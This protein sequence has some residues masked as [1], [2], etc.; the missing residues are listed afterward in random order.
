[1]YFPIF[2]F[3]LGKDKYIP[4]QKENCLRF[5]SYVLLTHFKKSMQKIEFP[6]ELEEKIWLTTK[7][8]P[9]WE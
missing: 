5:L 7:V 2:L 4:N 9:W 8:K 3:K 1:M 6:A